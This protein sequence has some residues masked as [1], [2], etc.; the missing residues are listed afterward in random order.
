MG[1]KL[2][3]S[4]LAEASRL[5]I[6]NI[7]NIHSPEDGIVAFNYVYPDNHL[8]RVNVEAFAN[9]LAEYPDGNSFVLSTKD[10][11][12]DPIVAGTLQK[13]TENA[14]GKP[15]PKLLTEVSEL[16]TT[17]ITKE[18]A[19]DCTLAD[20]AIAD[21]DFDLAMEGDSDDECFGLAALDPGSTGRAHAPSLS[22]GS[23]E[24][25]EK[26]RADLK[27]LKNSGYRVGVFGNIACSGILCVSIRVS[28][29][30]LSDE[31]LQAW[32]IQRKHY[33]LLL[34]RY[35][36]AIDLSKSM[37]M[38]VGLCD[39]YK[40]PL[41][42]VLAL[43][44]YTK[45]DNVTS[46]DNA[47][48]IS[49]DDP[50]FQQLFIGNAI[51]QLLEERVFKIISARQLYDLTWL[52][53]EKYINE[54]QATSSSSII[55]DMTPYHCSDD[56]DASNLPPIVLADHMR[57]ERLAKAS[58]PLIIMQFALRH[59]VRC[60]EFCLVCH[61]RVDDAF[62][63][64][65][66]YVCLKP[67]CLYQY[68]ALGFGPSLE[69]EIM[70]QPYVVD[71]LVSFC[72]AAARS[73][74]IKEFPIGMNLMVPVIPRFSEVSYPRKSFACLWSMSLRCLV[75]ADDEKK[76]SAVKN[77]KSGDWVVLLCR[78]AGAAAHCRV[79]R[80]DLPD[81]WLHEPISVP[82]PEHFRIFSCVTKEAHE[83]GGFLNAECYL[84]DKNFDDLVKEHQQG[85]I[86]TMLDALPG[87]I[88]MHRYLEGQGKSHELSL[89]AW[90]D[91]IPEST[92]N[93]L[94]W[95]VASNRSCIFQVDDIGSKNGCEIRG[96]AEDRVGGM[97]SWIQF[98]FAQ[99]APDKEKRFNKSV[100]RHA[101]ATRTKY[102]T[103][104]AW[105]GSPMGNWHSIIRQGLRYDDIL[106]GRSYGNGVYMSPHAS[107]SLGYTHEIAQSNCAWQGSF[108][109]IEKMLSLQEVVNDP[110][111]F[112]STMPHYVVPK[113]DWIQT[114]YLFVKT[115]DAPVRRDLAVEI[116]EQD[117]NR[118]AYNEACEVLSIPMTAI[119][120]ARRPGNSIDTTATPR[121]KR[122]KRISTTD[123][124]TAEQREDDADSVV[125]DADDL[126]LF[127]VA[128]QKYDPRLHD[129]DATA[130]SLCVSGKKRP[131]EVAVETDFVPGKL[132]VK[133]ITFMEAPQDATPVAT[134]A[135]MRLF[136]DA[137]KTQETTPPATLGWY[138][139]RNL[140]NNVYQWI[141]ELHSFP[142]DLPLA[143]D[144]K[145]AGVTS[146]VMEMRFTSQYP[147]S[148]PFI[149][150]VKP[151]FLPF[152]RGGGG[153][154]TDGGAMCM[155]VLTNNGWSASLSVES[156]LLQ[157][158]LVIC[159]TERPA[160][161]AHPPG[162]NYGI[163]EAI[164]AYIRACRNHG[165]KVP[166]GFETIQN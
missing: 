118:R 60:T 40:P 82:L 77:L 78:Q 66:P 34:I 30:G 140:V 81:V 124:A 160:R 69:W 89:K 80:V 5:G 125:S 131:A 98:R 150:V 32:N 6:D 31:A 156:L 141:V 147:F 64:L 1:R 65:K 52:G 67:L 74:R 56:P 95:I 37:D 123:L 159:D 2:F 16:L 44:Q 105:H 33:F 54:I 76:E 158:R 27:A 149:R 72:Y 87:V 128:D 14:H 153:N 24:K 103:L 151:R 161:L 152:N 165:W 144:M 43:Y 11:S 113:V 143:K 10:N 130:E 3:L 102:P 8:F 112:T 79:M 111:Q 90:S 100:E 127:Q 15:L 19:Q 36:G 91:R 49:K 42:Q 92:V 61:C 22:A 63:A 38:H 12:L 88:E 28:K 70:T 166:A 99:G 68:M 26:I 142:K 121:G 53:A 155:E 139:D 55:G 157:V 163:G 133:D 7:R 126:A 122:T 41:P 94:R 110:E 17:A 116:Y 62:E 106:H 86:M 164:A 83:N 13:V 137:L 135:L 154:V 96:K 162:S 145:D 47:D 71:L 109:K 136:R 108:L 114:R 119:S 25:M 57:Q 84:Y 18:S 51:N 120:K 9:D 97:A 45:P 20:Q 85:A 46:N 4:H 104:F 146:I 29:L 23:E 35:T 138:I 75:V 148:P 134:K 132:D 48:T 93:L 59:F 39:H 21:D 117:P 115:K 107:T 73:G 58:L 50:A 129:S 101:R